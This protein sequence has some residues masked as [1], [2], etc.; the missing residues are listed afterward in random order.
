MNKSTLNIAKDTSK[1]NHYQEKVARRIKAK[2]LAKQKQA[3]DEANEDALIDSYV[4]KEEDEITA[5][6]K[7]N[8]IKL[9]LFKQVLQK[10]QQNKPNLIQQGLNT[11]YNIRTI[12]GKAFLIT[13]SSRGKESK[14]CKRNSRMYI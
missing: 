9:E 10:T 14:I 4:T 8:N 2:Q 12:V 13:P 3:Y 7:K 6:A 5:K 1:S 11:T